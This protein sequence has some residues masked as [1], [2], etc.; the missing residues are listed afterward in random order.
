[1]ECSVLYDGSTTEETLIRKTITAGSH[2][3]SSKPTH[4]ITTGEGVFTMEKDGILSVTFGYDV[5][6]STY[7]WLNA[8]KSYAKVK[9]NTGGSKIIVEYPRP[10]E[11]VSIASNGMRV[12]TVSG[13]SVSVIGEKITLL[14]PNKKY[15][16][17]ITDSGVQIRRNSIDETS[18]TNL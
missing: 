18:W 14:S 13:A 12:L 11:G 9:F 7:A 2:G 17:R 5:H 4:R 8:D 15:G 3:H 10:I 16:L 1:M 6:L